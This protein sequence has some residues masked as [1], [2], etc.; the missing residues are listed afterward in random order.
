[1]LLDYINAVPLAAIPSYGEI[2]GLGDGLWAW[3]GSEL[4]DVIKILNTKNL[5]NDP[6]LQKEKAVALKQV[7]SLF[8]AHR[9]P[10]DFLLK[11][12]ELL[13]LKCNAYIRLLFKEGIITEALMRPM[14]ETILKFR[15]NPRPRPKENW[16]EQKTANS[17][18][19]KLLSLLDIDSLFS[20]DRLDASV[21]S[22]LDLDTQMAVTREM[23]KISG[24]KVDQRKKP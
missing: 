17:L 10:T 14:L 13:A 21:K 6:I 3:Y 22:T 20:L 8:I 19:T 4:E 24:C 7:L 11:N 18:R 12:R 15:E 5:S 2:F 9:R 1:M 23:N 16:V